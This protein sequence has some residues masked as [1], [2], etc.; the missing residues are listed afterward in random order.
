MIQIVKQDLI[1]I[2]DI[3]NTGL[4]DKNGVTNMSYILSTKVLYKNVVQ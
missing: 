4:S 1:D 3:K 2:I